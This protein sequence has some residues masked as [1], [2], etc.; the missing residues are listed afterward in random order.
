MIF[1]RFVKQFD[2]TAWG[3][4]LGAA[5]PGSL[6]LLTL[7]LLRQWGEVLPRSFLGHLDMLKS[8]S[9]LSLGLILG[10][11]ALLRVVRGR[12]GANVALIGL[13]CVW[14]F[15][16]AVEV[17][18]HQFY[19]S[20]GSTIDFYLMSFT[21]MHL[22]DNARVIGN[23]VPTD[24]Y[25]IL[26]FFVVLIATAPWMVKRRVLN[27]GRHELEDNRTDRPVLSILLLSVS[28]A[29]LLFAATLPAYSAPEGLLARASAVNVVLSAAQMAREELTSPELEI[30]PSTLDA[31]LTP[32]DPGAQAD[33]F[34]H[35]NLV[36]LLLE[37]TRA[38]SVTPYN[39]ALKTTPFLAE[40]AKKSTLAEHAYVVVPHSSKALVA[41]LCG[42][43]PS[44]HMPI[45]EAFPDHIPGRCLAELLG[46]QGYRSVFFQSATQDFEHRSQ[47]VKN[48]GF[49]DFRPGDEMD[50]T[51][52]SQANYF[53]YE[54]DIMLKPSRKWLEKHKDKPFFATYFTLTSHHPYLA[55]ERYG[56]H[57][58]AKDDLLN[59]YLNTVHY[60][61][62]FVENIFDQYKELGIYEDTIFVIVGDHGEGFGEHGR[63]QHDNVIYQEGVHVPLLIFDPQHPKR[64]DVA[65]NVNHLDLLPSAVKR[66]GF[67]IQDADY[68]GSALVD[69]DRQRPMRMNCWY[70]RRCM[71]QILGDQ[72]YIYHFGSQPDEFFDLRDDPDELNNLAKTHDDL[73]AQRNALLQWR[74]RSIGLHKGY[75]KTLEHSR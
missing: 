44:F 46:D 31:T 54:D 51:G 15:V 10:G 45:T 16:V 4:L 18:S 30:R 71:A 59:R 50:S 19:L 27:S 20:T 32:D 35:R 36:F 37:S 17:S 68:P 3:Y 8:V 23:E 66:L 38:S 75:A 26:L 74:R 58:F 62:R 64:Q 42:I 25:Y 52:F 12:L 63:Y 55:P 21:L 69:V 47:L 39:P 29:A 28:S 5:L 11:A 6:L 24:V 56:R 72:K 41:I 13:Q 61:D 53:G 33:D 22:A 1:R 65:Y 57:N 7:S 49:D 60:I 48:F 40:L 34:K 67:S 70:E 43:E 14:L 73:S 2:A 9:F